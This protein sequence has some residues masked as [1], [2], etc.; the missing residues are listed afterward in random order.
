MTIIAGQRLG[1]Y[2]IVAPLGA[3]G[4]GEVWRARDPELGRDVAIKV[5]PRI[6]LDR[7]DRMKRF[8]Q[9]ARATGLLNHPNLLTI[10]DTGSHDGTPFLVS[11]LL[12]G[13]TLRELLP[14]RQRKA[15]EY[16]LQ[17]ANGLAAAHDRGIV[18]R[19]LK[20]E[21]IFVTS[22]ER[23]K[24]LDF[25]LAK[26]LA[27]A[28]A[29]DAQTATI[30]RLTD[31]GS[32]I[33]TVAYMSPEQVR[34][35]PVDHRSD[36][37][38]FGTVLH[39]MLSG[40]SPFRRDS[41]LDT[42]NAILSDEP[43]APAAGDKLP[44]ALERIVGHALE[45]N[46][47]QRFQTMKD[48]AFAIETFSGSGE[49]TA[50][51]PKARA[52][53]TEK[54][55]PVH[56]TTV[57]FRRGFIMS[58]RFARDGSVVYGAAW[59]DKPLELFASF[60]GDPH[61]RPL[62]IG[63][64]D[65][66]SVNPVTGELAISIGRKY[67]RGWVSSGTLAR[68]SASGGAPRVLAE[69]VQDADWG[70]DGKALAVIRPSA[71]GFAIEYPLGHPI[72][73]TS[74]WISDV[75]VSPKG[76]LLAFFDHPVWGDDGG[77]LAVI[78]LQGE[79]R[80]HSRFWKSAAGVAWTPRGDEVWCGGFGEGAGRDLVAVSVSGKKDRVLMPMPGRLRV[81]D[82]RPG[83]DLLM[84][85]EVGRREIQAGARGGEGERNLTWCDWSFLTDLSS[86]GSQVVI[87]EQ[88]GAGGERGGMYVRPVDGG[89][90]VYFGEGRVR[91]M[92]PDRK[93]IA[94]MTGGPDHLELLPTGAGEPKTVPV[95]G[96]EMSVWWFWFPDGKR[97][98]VW[99][100]EP[101]RRQRM[102]E[103]TI[104]GDG[105]ARPIGPEGV[106][107]PIAIA[108]DGSAAAAI[109]PEGRLM[110]YPISN[111]RPASEVPASRAE[112]HPLLWGSD[113]ALYVYQVGRIRTTI[114]RID[115]ASGIRSEWQE[116]KPSD[117]AGVMNIQPAYVSSDLGTYAYCYRRFLS[118]LYVVTG[119][120]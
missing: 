73:T 43:A 113:G 28:S 79:K 53:R 44:A 81:H 40:T 47:S 57:T 19:D 88:G 12:E 84:S 61:A 3:G 38:S 58:A 54:K 48:V 25:G 105:T 64:A 22:D 69:D 102:F 37:F 46:P 72:Y 91:T 85:G 109:G 82:I 90:A 26:L 23:V 34:G 30:E 74:H 24:L 7:D 2:E 20:P 100:N 96:L 98:L 86:D 11:E 14:L 27:D 93:W 59:E 116:L 94:A 17:I 35:Q 95:R 32:I 33:G 80:I 49:S 60:P 89:P 63:E 65:V 9:E 13:Q 111:D 110:M 10:F 15:V 51:T 18:H 70:P 56:F 39:E 42:M 29:P 1:R 114:D 76:D 92:S 120:S 66:L 31:P 118:E 4:M 41:Q 16:A 115:L 112:D 71:A 83:G 78:D 67:S 119:V 103:V 50:M 52:K 87:E 101:N 104:D 36:I 75:R 6:S 99:G 107:L 62:G 117:A 68:V 97:L 77:S 8:A 21:N 45:K 108:P 5:L 106:Q 55:K